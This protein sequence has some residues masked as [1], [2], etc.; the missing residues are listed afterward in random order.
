MTIVQIHRNEVA[1]KSPSQDK[2][3]I[4]ILAGNAPWMK[5]DGVVIRG[6]F[7]SF[8]YLT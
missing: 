6:C 3:I 4:V 2:D 8:I 5:T 7:F 1:G